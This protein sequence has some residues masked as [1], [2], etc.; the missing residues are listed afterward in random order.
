MPTDFHLTENL[1]GLPSDN[2]SFREFRAPREHGS[3]VIEPAL[4]SSGQLLRS[5]LKLLQSSNSTWAELRRLARAELVANAIRYTNAYR[6]TSWVGSTD[7]PVVMAGHQPQVFHPGV[8]IKNFALHQIAKQR[9]AI[10]VNL[11]VDNDVSSGSSLRIP[12]ID[13]QTGLAAYRSV[14]FD[15]AGGGI[16]YEQRSIRDRVLFD[17]FPNK[18]RSLVSPLVS[19]PCVDRLWHHA[20]SALDRCGF[21]GCAFAQARHGLEDEIGLRTLE[22][23]LG[24]ACRSLGFARFVIMILSD[25][26]RFRDCYNEAAAYYRREH[27][28]RSSAHPVP[29]LAQKDGM[30]EAP[31]WIYSDASPKRKAAWVGE[32]DSQITIS[33]GEGGSISL[34]KGDAEA[35]A[36]QLLDAMSSTN[37]KLRPRALMTTMYARL[38]LSDLFLHGI[39]GA[40]YDQLGDLICRSFFGVRP[41]GYM[42]MSATVTLPGEPPSGLNTARSDLLREIR[43]TR[44]QPERFAEVDQTLAKRKRQLLDS[45][46]VR[47]QRLSWHREVTRLNDQMSASLAGVRHDL[48]GRM[49]KNQAE[50][51]SHS[52]LT[53]REHPFCVFPMTYLVET[54]GEIL[55]VDFG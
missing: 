37:F 19:D 12:T 34:I 10:A 18:V 8:W 23:P 39:G 42:V 40:K 27:G 20:R 45:I 5:N 22:I 17:A 43:D 1:V 32:A 49:R 4:S 28:I 53:S 3:A 7:R 48:E 30:I 2:Q 6:D 35:A 13:S 9:D 41:P 52:V 44:F 47:G 24:V 33:D 15:T 50:I 21:A 55:G 29:D 25:L 46:P 26:A 31:F 38:V 36:Q 14:S 16:P 54:F 11:V 51:A